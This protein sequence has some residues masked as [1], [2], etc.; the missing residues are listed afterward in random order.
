[1]IQK[2]DTCRE[3][4]KINSL[5]RAIKDGKIYKVYFIILQKNIEANSR[6]LFFNSWFFLS[7]LIREKK[8]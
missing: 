5:L 6:Q 2:H 7:C 8:P 4:F 1:M 3:I